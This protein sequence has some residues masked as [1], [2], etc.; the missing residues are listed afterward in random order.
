MGADEAMR[1]KTKHLCFEWI[2]IYS[3]VIKLKR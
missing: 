3:T 1:V 2:Q